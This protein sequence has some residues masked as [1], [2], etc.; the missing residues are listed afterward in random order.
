VAATDSAECKKLAVKLLA[1]R[2]HSRFE[3]E[4]KL[5]ARS[6]PLELV[7]LALDEL[8]NSGAIAPAR[9]AESFIRSRAAKGQGPVRIRRELKER[10]I[11]ETLCAD[12]L[13]AAEFDWAHIAAKV[14]TKRFGSLAPKDFTERARQARFLQY[15]G[16]DTGQIDAALDLGDE[17]D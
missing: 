11:E 9:F 6:F 2:E 10:G 7:S 5:A 17:S 14:R 3:L 1:R 8:E 15:R 12:S 4:R 13:R 16:F